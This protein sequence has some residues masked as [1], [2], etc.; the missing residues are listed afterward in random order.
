MKL[1]E[2]VITTLDDLIPIDPHGL[3]SERPS[4]LFVPSSPRSRRRLR[5][6]DLFCGCGGFSLGMQEAGLNVVAAVEW[7][8]WAIQ[9]YLSNLGS[10]TG[11]AVAYLEDTDR[12]RHQKVLKKS[13]LTKSSGWIGEHN[14]R[15]DGSGCRAMVMGDVT[16][17][18]G[19]LVRE[20]LA[21]INE[22][23]T[24]DVVIGGPPCQGMSSAGKQ[25]PDD[26]RNNLVLEYVRLADELGA[27]VFV[28]ENVPPLITQAKYRPLFEE[29]IRRANAAGFSVVANV[30][31]AANYGVPQ[32]RARAFVVGTRGEADERPFTYPMP[33]TWAFGAP[34]GKKRWSFLE[35]DRDE[36]PQPRT[37]AKPRKVKK[38]RTRIGDLFR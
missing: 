5:V 19:D 24:I 38:K 17:V 12:E 4:G 34:V 20:T 10:A 23:S 2:A 3:W 13:K 27:D 9:T 11:C 21:A 36:R 6:A 26:P 28:M 7:D 22:D 33:T 15:R 16:K 18:T 25:R 37:P 31:D 1:R 8:P 14:P 32:R 29:L 30:L 35:T